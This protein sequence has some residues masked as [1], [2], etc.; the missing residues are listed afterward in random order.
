MK[1]KGRVVLVLLIAVAVAAAFTLSYA[2]TKMPDQPIKIDS[3]DAYKE[4]KKGAVTFPHVKHK[5]LKCVECH[6]EFK[7]GKNVWQEGQEV[8]KCAACHK[9]KKEGKKEKLEKAFH[10]KC[11]TCHKKLKEEKKPTGPVTCVKC[12]GKEKK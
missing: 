12:H 7:D 6:H 5:A 1:S 2:A 3:K 8:K 9:D 10:K 4:K 11:Q